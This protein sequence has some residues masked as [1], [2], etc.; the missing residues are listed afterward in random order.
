MS[1]V[2]HPVLSARVAVVVGN[3]T[4]RSRTYESALVLADRL[5]GADMFVPEAGLTYTGDPVD[6]NAVRTWV[7]SLFQ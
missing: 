4:P 5:G 7:G 3:P 1:T 6:E 2:P